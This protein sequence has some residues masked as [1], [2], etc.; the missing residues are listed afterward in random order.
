MMVPELPPLL[1]CKFLG[2]FLD[3]KVMRSDQ[4]SE[5]DLLRASFVYF[6][7]KGII[8]KGF[9]GFSEAGLQAM[10]EE[11]YPG[12]AIDRGFDA[13]HVYKVTESVTDT[14][15]TMTIVLTYKLD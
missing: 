12:E 3:G 13:R 5:T 15:G 14:D 2:G 9:R 6:S 4:E 10:K 1:I 11:T 7:T 8:G